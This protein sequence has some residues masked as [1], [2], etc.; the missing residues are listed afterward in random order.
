MAGSI[1]LGLLQNTAILLAFSMLYDNLWIK[2]DNLQSITF[3][4]INGTIIG[5]IGIVLMLSPWTLVEGLVFDTRSVVLGIS[6]LFFGTVPTIIAIIINIAY[7]AY[8]GGGGMWMGIAVIISSGV[9]GLLWRKT[10]PQWMNGNKIKELILMGTVVHVAMLFCSALLPR[11]LIVPTFQKIALPIIIVYIPATV[12]IGLLML[13]NYEG[14]QNKRV[15][16]QLLEDTM[17]FER[18]LMK[19]NRVIREQNRRYRKLNIE[20]IE[21][22]EKAEES[23]R[24]KSAFLANMSHEIRTPMNGILGFADLLENP[25][26]SGEEV[27]EYI[28]II[29]YS[30]SRMLNIINDLIEI[31]K[32]DSGLMQ[33][34]IAPVDVNEK[35]DFMYNFFKPEAEKKGLDLRCIKGLSDKESVIACDKE[36]LLSILTNLL[37]NSVKYSKH[38][39]IEFGYIKNNKFLEFY[40]KDNGIGIPANRQKNIFERFVQVDSSFSSS[41]EGAGL[42]LAIAKAFVEMLGGNI[43]LE[44]EEGVGSTFYF[45]IPYKQVEP[46][47][48]NSIQSV[49]L[50]AGNIKILLVEDEPI[51]LIL[52]TKLVNRYTSKILTATNGREAIEACK[53]N[54]DIDI[55]LMDIKMPEVDGLEAAR[56][57][58]EFNKNVTIIAQTA[59]ALAGDKELALEAGCND[60]ISK[61]VNAKKLGE[62]IMRFVPTET[63]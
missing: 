24:L 25:D 31:S 5:S 6:G 9:I 48:G 45:T 12:L 62:M 13:K 41:Y 30:G 59:Y 16:E 63:I 46:E 32:V 42:G 14:W 43:R 52:L 11:E 54:A 38:G 1:L 50:P 17:T 8:L 26:L 37:K 15:K 22:K 18:S 53:V 47:T 34:K 3:K 23:D 10:R 36:K 19:K 40:V 55:I 56:S 20:L 58:R 44:S 60:Y 29:K 4:L 57:I 49:E 21:A 2:R 39:L 35:I 51:S 7:R 28:E 61:P 33:V 27:K